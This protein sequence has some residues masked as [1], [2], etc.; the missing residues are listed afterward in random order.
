MKIQFLDENNSV[1]YETDGV[2][3]VKK[4]VYDREEFAWVEHIQI[5][6]QVD[7]DQLKNLIQPVKKVKIISSTGSIEYDITVSTKVTIA[8]SASDSTKTMIVIQQ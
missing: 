6:C 7:Y 5:R 4:L 1:L 2:Y 8:R 3:A